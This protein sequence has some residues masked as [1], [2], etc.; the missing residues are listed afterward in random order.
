MVAPKGT[1]AKGAKFI[2]VLITDPSDADLVASDE[3][4][5]WWFNSTDG[6][7]KFWDGTYISIV[8]GTFNRSKSIAAEALGLPNTN[9][10]TIVD[11]DN[12]TLYKFTVDTDKV[13]LK[14]EVPVDYTTGTDL[15]FLIVWTNDGGVD[16]NGKKVK[17]Q[18]DYQV[19]T[20]GDVISGSHANSPK[21]I[22]DTYT[23]AS[24][25]VEH[26]TS[27]M[28]IPAA[29]FLDKQCVFLKLSAIT[30]LAT[31]LSCEPHLIGICFGYTTRRS[32]M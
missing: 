14:L 29:D 12:L 4:G 9:P 1:I 27:A 30:A 10:P 7:F 6:V 5:W 32:L 23:S 3:P 26:H 22:D 11:Q 13:T 2:G 17:W 18:L 15:T 21:T 24:G 31:V 19:G 28:T 25:W 16:D 20:E 8:G